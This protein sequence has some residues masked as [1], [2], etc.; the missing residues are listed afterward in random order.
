MKCDDD[1]LNTLL[2]MKYFIGQSAARTGATGDVLLD[3]EDIEMSIPAS[4][5]L[6]GLL[7][8]K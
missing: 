7:G 5:I 3:D 4:G 8:K 1:Y 2:Y 6:E